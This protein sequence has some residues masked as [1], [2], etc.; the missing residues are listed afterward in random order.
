M[1]K[2]PQRIDN[3]DIVDNIDIIDQKGAPARRAR[4]GVALVVTLG[5]LAVICVTV[6]AFIAA[7][8]LERATAGLES[9]RA[10]LR[11]LHHVGLASAMQDLTVQLQMKVVGDELKP[12]GRVYAT[13]WF[14]PTAVG[15]CFGSAYE[16]TNATFA[17]E[18]VALFT[19]AATNLVPEAVRAEAE[20]V[21]SYWIPLVS[22][23]ITQEN[24][25]TRDPLAPLL[26][27]VV[28]GRIAYL[29]ID[30]SGFLP[31]VV[32]NAAG[33]ARR[34]T[35]LPNSAPQLLPRPRFHPDSFSP[36]S[37]VRR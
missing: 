35:S 19:G 15:S 30:C 9:D 18:S 13:D 17:A 8:R 2:K 31:P 25:E 7:M 26:D 24:E 36:S 20:A 28:I 6:I 23:L 32:S 10:E 11:G 33:Y 37:R 4:S 22:S 14:W 3:I 34:S 5:L 27:T 21:E 1:S 16:Q 29:V 12:R